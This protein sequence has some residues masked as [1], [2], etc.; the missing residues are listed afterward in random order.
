M[1]TTPLVSVVMAV[2]NGERF[3]REAMDS[4]LQQSFRDLEFIVIDDGSTDQSGA[5]LDSYQRNDPRVRVIH[6]ENKKLVESLNRGCALATGKYIA[7]M[8]ADDVA[9]P[10]RLAW[11]IEFLEA[12]PEV[13]VLGGAVQFIDHSGKRLGIAPRP[14][15]PRDVKRGLLDSSVVWHP[16]AVIRAS[17]L[18]ETGGYR[19]AVVDAE[20][21]DL[22]LRMADRFEL[23]NLA[24]VV[25]HYRI[26]P[27]QGSVSRC[28]K[29]ALA[30]AAARA[31]AQIRRK[32]EPDPLNF[33]KEIT[34]DV[35]V[36]LGVTPAVQETTIARGYLSSV[37]NL[38][39]I[40][41]YGSALRM[42][43][44]ILD[45]SEIKHAEA[46]TLADLRLC[47]A[48]I[49]WHNG[50]FVRSVFSAIH[51]ALTRPTILC[52]PLKPLLNRIRLADA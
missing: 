41:E 48:R 23:A 4:I 18:A 10:D 22:W 43:D 15:H 38:C 36:R 26:H 46:W 16:S 32:G 13:A 3:L 25:L 51:A 33:V 1:T 40:G 6:Q 45:S 21:Y 28:K 19:N 39:D 8:D 20:D 31:A 47:A 44:V 17:A 37:R 2:F 30:C 24:A 49:H 5:I 34:P 12:H 50:N 7:R 35:L 14:V 42:L 11:Q 52:R 9:V 29:Q 27:G